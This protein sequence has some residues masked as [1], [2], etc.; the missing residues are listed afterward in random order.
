MIGRMQGDQAKMY[1]GA[2]VSA[3]GF[4]GAAA[5]Y[6][7]KR[8]FK[9]LAE[10]HRSAIVGN[11]V[12]AG[13]RRLAASGAAISEAISASR[14]RRLPGGGRMGSSTRAIRSRGGA[15]A[16]ASSMTAA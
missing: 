6:T 3:V 2:A 1:K 10:L 13:T 7:K 16:A 4:G 14:P 12:A 9:A 8:G 15:R 11:D 5:L